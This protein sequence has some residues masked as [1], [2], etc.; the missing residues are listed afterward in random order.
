[1]Y[2]RPDSAI[3]VSELPLNDAYG[4]VCPNGVTEQ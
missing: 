2:I 4:P 1:M 3:A